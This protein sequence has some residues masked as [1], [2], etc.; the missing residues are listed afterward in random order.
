MEGCGNIIDLERILKLKSSGISKSTIENI[1]HWYY[2]RNLSMD[3][4]LTAIRRVPIPKIGNAKQQ[5]LFYFVNSLL[6]LK[7]NI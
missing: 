2:S 7:A 1:K 6:D 5:K 3:E 4:A